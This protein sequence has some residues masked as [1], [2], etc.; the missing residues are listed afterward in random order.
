MESYTFT[1]NGTQTLAALTNTTIT[2]HT[3]T[4]LSNDFDQ[5]QIV[6]MN[7]PLSWWIQGLQNS[8]IHYTPISNSVNWSYNDYE[9]SIDVSSLIIPDTKDEC[10]PDH[11]TGVVTCRYK[12]KFGMGKIDTFTFELRP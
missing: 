10:V 5:N 3:E 4:D 1:G 7:L 8:S 11:S 6:F 2:S 9:I 12:E